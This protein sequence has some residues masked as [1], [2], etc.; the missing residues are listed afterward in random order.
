V[1]FCVE[2]AE[3]LGWRHEANALRDALAADLQ[4]RGSILP[5]TAIVAFNNLA[6]GALWA[7]DHLESERWALR[8]LNMCAEFERRRRISVEPVSPAGMR[9]MTQQWITSWIQIGRARGERKDIKGAREAFARARQAAE[10]IGDTNARSTLLFNEAQLLRREGSSVEQQIELTRRAWSLAIMTGFAGGMTESALE[11]GYVLATIGEYDAALAASERAQRTAHWSGSLLARLG[12]D[13]LRAEVAARRS[14]SAEAAEVFERAIALAEDDPILMARLRL[15]AAAALA[16]HPSTRAKALAHVDRVL[17]EMAQSRIPRNG[18]NRLVSEDRVWEI[19]EELERIAESTEPVLS[20]LPEGVAEGERDLRSLLLQ[21]EHEGDAATV[22]GVL[23][24]LANSRYDAARPRRMLDLAQGAARAA[25]RSGNPDDRHRALHLLAMADDL[26]GDF[27]GAMAVSRELLDASPPASEKLRIAASQTLAI[28][29]AKVGR[30]AE[31][32]ALLRDILAYRARQGNVAEET[33]SITALA[34]TLARGGDP[35]GARAVLEDGAAVIEHSGDRL[36][37]AKRDDMLAALRQQEQGGRIPAPLLFAD[38]N[39]RVSVTSEQL[40]QLRRKSESPHEL[41]DIAALALVSGHTQTAVDILLHAQASFLQQSD[42]QG[43]V[44]CF[45][46]L[47]DAAQVEGRWDSAIDFTRH[48]LNLAEDLDDLPGQT[49]S[50][51]AMALQSMAVDQF[52][53]AEWAARHCLRFARPADNLRFTTI[54]RC[55]LAEIGWRTAP[56]RATRR[57]VAVMRGVLRV[58]PDL[59]PALRVWLEHRFAALPS[60]STLRSW[61]HGLLTRLRSAQTTGS[62]VR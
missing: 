25:E 56:G 38:G 8:A 34:D 12:P 31:A 46:L 30:T 32:E 62:A 21:A 28:V 19:K 47:A 23:R 50:Y 15:L 16:H 61:W 40:V 24:N 41:C 17:G 29:L 7:G 42:T 52:D 6:I 18:S 20:T 43:Q 35:A 54:A 58:A 53:R 5:V 11:E 60:H 55:S 9:Q 10:E 4:R 59:P 27:Q 26:A 49:S 57:E 45:H 51:A 39:V 3:D 48:A 22:A 13:L 33:R 1:H 37:L 2:L 36:A 44:R 14:Q